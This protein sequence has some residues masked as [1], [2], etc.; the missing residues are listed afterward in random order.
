MLTITFH[1]SCNFDLRGCKKTFIAIPSEFGPRIIKDKI[2]KIDYLIHNQGGKLY[3]ITM[4]CQVLW[5]VL[6]LPNG[7]NPSDVSSI[8]TLCGSDANFG[9]F[10]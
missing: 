9:C 8:L 4:T 1:N 3:R 6:M 10:L 2:K 7:L 5:V